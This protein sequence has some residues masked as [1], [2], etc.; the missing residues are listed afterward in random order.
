MFFAPRGSSLSSESIWAVTSAG[1]W[2]R[3][4]LP[5]G[6]CAVGAPARRQCWATP[7]ARRCFERK[8]TY[9]GVVQESFEAGTE[10]DPGSATISGGS[11]LLN[12]GSFF[13]HVL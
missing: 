3:S 2:E 6:C 1:C 8:R 10:F 12:G 7:E 5:C 11:P 13:S 4:L 9:H